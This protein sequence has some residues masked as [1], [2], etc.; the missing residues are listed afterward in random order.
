MF[1]DPVTN[2]KGWE[3]VELGKLC[4]RVVDCAHTTPTYSEDVRPYPCVRSSD[5]QAW[6]FDW[7]STKTVSQRI[8]ET[9][10]K[11]HIPISGDVVFCREGARFGNAARIPEGYKI[12]LGQRMMIFQALKGTATA[13]Y[14]WA[15]LN[16]SQ[17]AFAGIA[18][19]AAAPRVNIKDLVGLKVMRPP[20]DVQRHFSDLVGFIDRIKEHNRQL[21]EENENLFNSLVQRAFCGEL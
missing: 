6:H 12:C 1:G 8:Y 20:I 15:L 3:V 9:R 7:S 16:L 11:R 21:H 10:T 5:I 17:E 13:E 18:G 4:Q 14:L 19:G 2:P